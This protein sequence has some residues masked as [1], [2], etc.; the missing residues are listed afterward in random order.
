MVNH[1]DSDSMLLWS[2]QSK[3]FQWTS[4]HLIPKQL[5]AKSARL[6]WPS[7][8]IKSSKITS[9]WPLTSKHSAH[10]QQPPNDSTAAWRIPGQS[11]CLHAEPSDCRRGFWSCVLRSATWNPE[12]TLQQSGSVPGR[13]IYLRCYQ[14]SLPTTRGWMSSDVCVSVFFSNE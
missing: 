3:H 13:Q 6:T 14:R 2:A 1:L 4:N 5:T 11:F 9:L 12:R 8:D 7:V 10:T